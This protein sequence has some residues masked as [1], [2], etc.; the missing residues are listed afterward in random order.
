MRGVRS[1]HTGCKWFQKFLFDNGLRDSKASG[2]R[3]TWYCR[4]LSQRL[5]RAIANMDWDSFAPNCIVRNLHRLKSDHR[6]IFIAIQLRQNKGERLFHCLAIWF[7]HVDF[8]NV[9]RNSWNN[10]R[11]IVESLENFKRVISDWNKKVYSNIF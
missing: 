1:S 6:P 7:C 5:D 8:K 2:A 11:P 9:I 3:F 4:G 10:D